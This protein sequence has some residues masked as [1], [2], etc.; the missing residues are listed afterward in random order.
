MIVAVSFLSMAAL[1]LST[2]RLLTDQI[3]DV[4]V[5]ATEQAAQ[6]FHNNLNSQL[7]TMISTADDWAAWDETYYF[8]EN[9][10]TEYV[11]SNLMDAT[12]LNL[13]L[14]VMIYVNSI[15]QVVFSKTVYENQ[16]FE[17]TPQAANQLLSHY[18]LD[19]KNYNQ[20]KSGIVIIQGVPVLVAAHPILNSF[21][22]APMRGELII[23]RYLDTRAVAEISEVIGLPITVFSLDSLGL[24]DHVQVAVSHLSV[25]A[26]VFVSPINDSF[27]AGYTIIEDT[28]GA[29][30][31]V[32]ELDY[33]RS[34]YIQKNV[35]STYTSASFAVAMVVSF[36][37]TLL[38]LDKTIISRLTRLNN[39]VKKS[40]VTNLQQVKAEGNDEITNLACSINSMID[41]IDKSQKALNQQTQTLELNVQKRTKELTENR[42]KIES[43]LGASPD[44]IIATDLAG[45]II[46]ANQKMAELSGAKREDLI[47]ALAAD[48]VSQPLFLEVLAKIRHALSRRA[49]AV[50]F[51]CT[52]LRKDGSTYPAEVSVGV[53]GGSEGEPLGVVAVV[54]DITDKKDIQERLFNSERLAGI[55]QTAS[56]V[57]HDIRNPLQ[58]IL[59][60]L[61]L[62]RKGLNK[63]P[64]N[65]GS[66]EELGESIASIEENVLYINK[67][68]SDL[69]DYTRSLKPKI[70]DVALRD[71][72]SKVIDEVNISKVIRV[73]ITVDEGL[74]VNTDAYYLRRILTNLVV[75]GVQAMQNGGSLSIN[76][77]VE[78]DKLAIK[79]GD[80]GVGIPEEAM[81][82]LFKPLFTT[83]SKGQGLGLAVVKRL[84]DA[85]NGAVTVESKEGKGTVFCIY[86]PIKPER[87]VT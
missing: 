86:L 14:N 85:L 26:P 51:E 16:T 4:E 40:T 59:C 68:V 7:K 2:E 34:A 5:K 25:D 39:A 52:L 71:F 65:D 46:E 24:P 63:L 61:Y 17:V 19:V 43:I 50:S 64:D 12:F 33:Y 28:N 10:N 79:V 35:S 44:A 56:M 77:F 83:K 18:N 67:I 9:N 22:E 42:E 75:N 72:V 27:T 66:H 8:I 11:T 41:T 49:K 37:F 48:Y 81:P 70:E 58:A 3:T 80:T 36:V 87:Q 31:L 55:G 1:Y 20:T 29:P 78:G 54:R 32:A 45:N 21:H 62:L 38:L 73:D 53:I 15:G 84:I 57:G 30:A 13:D 76:A 82:N 69:Q 60:D 74:V 23:G 47:G 6:I